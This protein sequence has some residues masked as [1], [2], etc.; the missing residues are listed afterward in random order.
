MAGI[1]SD[2]FEETH[3]EVK[4]AEDFFFDFWISI[5]LDCAWTESSSSEISLRG[6]LLQALFL[7]TDLDFNSELTLKLI[8][9][10]DLDLDFVS[11]FDFDF[12]LFLDSSSLW[13]LNWSMRSVTRRR[14]LRGSQVASD[15]G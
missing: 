4:R 1:E 13:L 14:C 11:D 12:D 9:D 2:C 6:L 3:A 5:D 15:R 8:S 7:T 10:F